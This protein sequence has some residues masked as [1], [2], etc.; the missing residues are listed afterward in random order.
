[1]WLKL[2]EKLACILK[3]M[4]SSEIKRDIGDLRH[5]LS[6]LNLLVAQSQQDSKRSWERIYLRLEELEEKLK[7]C[8]V[9]AGRP[10]PPAKEEIV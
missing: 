10:C 3:D 9:L 1:M 5:D 8:P 4:I 2:V 6:D 7:G